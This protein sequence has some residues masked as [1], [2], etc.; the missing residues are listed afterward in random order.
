M[1]YWRDCSS[2]HTRRA[3]WGSRA[4]LKLS[5]YHYQWQLIFNIFFMFFVIV[6]RAESIKDGVPGPT[7]EVVP[8]GPGTPSLMDV[9]NMYTN[10]PTDEGKNTATRA[11][12]T[13]THTRDVK[14]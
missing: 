12:K 8:A 13:T 1:K 4:G 14:H 11:L 3:G 10:I 7:G 5:I 6:C 2:G 9:T